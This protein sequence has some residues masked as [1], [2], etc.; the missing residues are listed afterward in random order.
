MSRTINFGI[1]GCGVIGNTHAQ[2]IQTVPEVANLAAVCD[3]IPERANE[4]AKKY[5]GVPY[6]SLD[7]MLQHPGLDAINVCTPSGV[8]AECVVAAANK[9]VNALC[10]KPMD[11][12]HAKLDAIVAASRRVKVGCVFQRR[13]WDIT[14]KIKAAIDGGDLGKLFLATAD[15]KW[16]RSQEYYDSGDWRGTWELDGGGALM[17]Q[18]IHGA[19]LLLYLMGPIKSV[20]AYAATLTHKI[21]VEDTLVGI[22]KFENGALGTLNVTTSA[23][24][25][26]TMVHEIHGSRGTIGL[27][28]QGVTI[29]NIDGKDVNPE[30]ETTAPDGGASSD[31]ANLWIDGHVRL[32]KDMAEAIRDDRDPVITPDVGRGAVDFVLALYEAAKTG[33]EVTLG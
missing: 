11:I 19:D 13:V 32:V 18:G 10:E 12:T 3:I 27:G 26:R 33:K 2:A 20:Q 5:G 24:P 6:Y 17:N 4:F 1:V 29:W 23:Q 25:S 14:R 15:M 7:E 22:I 30:A 8:H 28:E 21:D 9:G 31:P 16:Y